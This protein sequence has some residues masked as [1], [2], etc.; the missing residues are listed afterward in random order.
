MGQVDGH[1]LNGGRGSGADGV[2]GEM[3]MSG[4]GVNNGKVTKEKS[5]TLRHNM[6]IQF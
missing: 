4:A 2:N 5:R 1:R 6:T 3:G